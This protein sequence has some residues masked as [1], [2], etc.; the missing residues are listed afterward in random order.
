MMLLF[1]FIMVLVIIGAVAFIVIT[2]R[3]HK[4]TTLSPTY[5]ANQWKA[6]LQCV[7][8]G[9]QGWR[10]AIIDADK[11]LDHALKQSGIKGD[12]MGSRLREAEKTFMHY[13]QLWAAHK[14]RN[15]LVHEPGVRLSKDLTQRSL[16]EFQ[17]ALKELGALK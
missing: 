17:R 2:L 12:D 1:E 15:R 7:A 10:L 5:Y 6:V 8:T 11:L 3:S 9:E 13:N 4:K 14:L 16:R